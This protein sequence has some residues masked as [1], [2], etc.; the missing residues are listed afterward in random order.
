MAR[1]N[2]IPKRLVSRD[3]NR[4]FPVRFYSSPSS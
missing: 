3:A 4:E 2:T 1:W